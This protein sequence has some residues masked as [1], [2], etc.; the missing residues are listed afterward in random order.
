MS[1]E[2]PLLQECSP[3]FPRHIEGHTETHC[4]SKIG[5]REN[6]IFSALPLQPVGATG[7]CIFFSVR[8]R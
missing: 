2:C 4:L 8:E 5:I 3:I 7:K 6:Q 1:P